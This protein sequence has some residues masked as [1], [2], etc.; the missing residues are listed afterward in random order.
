[1]IPAETVIEKILKQAVRRNKDRFPEDF[2]F[3]LS[4]EEFTILRS[5]FV[6]SSWGGTRS[7][8]A[9]KCTKQ[10]TGNSGKYPYN[11]SIYKDARNAI[12]YSKFEN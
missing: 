9:L 5:Q 1:M 2:M 12:R 7:S 4:N 3:E 11:A 10:Q 8:H 6:T